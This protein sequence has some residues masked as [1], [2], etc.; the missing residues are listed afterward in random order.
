MYANRFV[1]DILCIFSSLSDFKAVTEFI[2][3]SKDF[4]LEIDEFENTLW[5]QL[6]VHLFKN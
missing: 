2:Y 4:D 3:L 5:M 6:I 1:S